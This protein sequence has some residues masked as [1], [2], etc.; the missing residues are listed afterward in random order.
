MK[1][2]ILDIANLSIFKNSKP[3]LH[4]SSLVVKNGECV[5]LF[6]DSGSGKSVFSLFLL[7]LLN[8]SVFTVSG[9]SAVFFKRDG[10]T[11]N[12]FSKN[13]TDWNSFRSSNISLI[14]QDPSAALNPTI[15]CG[16][17]IEEVLFFSKNKKTECLQLLDEVDL[18]DS[19]RVYNSFP[20]EL[21]G[22]EKQRVVIA[23]ALASNPDFLIADEPTT[24]LDPLTQRGILDLIMRIVKSRSIGVLLISHNLE[25]VDFFC[26]RVYFFYNS[27]FHLKK[28][29]LGESYFNKKNSVLNSIK[30]RQSRDFLKKPPI[31]E[32]SNVS[33]LFNSS[34]FALKNISFSLFR[35]EILGVVGGSG[36]GKTTLGRVLCGLQKI[37]SGS[38]K[39]KQDVD[40]IKKNVQL[41]YQDPF[42]SFNPKHTVGD[43]VFE[44]IKLYKT[45]HTV[46]GLFKKVQ[47]D[48]FLINRYPHELSGGQKQRVSIARVLASNPQVIV[49]DESLS[50]LDIETQYSILKLIKS[51]SNKLNIS[52]VFISHNMRSV[53]YLCDRVVVLKR[54]TIVDSFYGNDFF[55]KKRNSFTKKIIN[56]ALF[57]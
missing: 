28:S 23:I 6:G 30:N 42:S 1:R 13:E 57:L 44:I 26:D 12:L 14:F 47:L 50:G 37:H 35:G 16:S 20:H 41:V 33:V 17:Q 49:F 53:Y 25:L 51:I 21:S 3:L 19:V 32:L 29:S 24:S 7:G 5:G 18:V 31:F 34:F 36:S 2:L 48:V 39:Q 27:G 9:G 11:F 54:G 46:E 56:D 43:A 4:S 45:K 15:K 10:S 52:I 22:G 38:F 55:S 8:R 40:F